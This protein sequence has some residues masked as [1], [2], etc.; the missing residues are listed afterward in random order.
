V[1]VRLL[2]RSDDKRN[3]MQVR[4][5]PAELVFVS[6]RLLS[7]SDDYRNGM[8]VRVLPAELVFVSIRLLSRSDDKRNGMQVRVL[9]AELVFVGGAEVNPDSQMIG[10]GSSY[11]RIFNP[12]ILVGF[13]F[14]WGTFFIYCNQNILIITTSGNLKIPKGVWSFIILWKKDI[15]HVIDPGSLCIR[16]NAKRGLKQFISR[17]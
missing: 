11:L 15:L 5:L 13:R 10:V 7:R 8:Q 9:P 6:I 17:N 3:G 16:K 14:L 4:V 1:S 2:S 12:N